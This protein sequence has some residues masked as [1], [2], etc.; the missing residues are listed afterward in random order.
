MVF[1]VCVWLCIFLFPLLSEAAGGNK[2]RGKHQP[3]AKH[4]SL[5]SIVRLLLLEDATPGLTY[6]F[7]GL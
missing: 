2:K 5:T 3:A 1:F 7:L 4:L 6:Y